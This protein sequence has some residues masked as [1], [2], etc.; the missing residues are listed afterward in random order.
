MIIYSFKQRYVRTVVW[1]YFFEITETLND[2]KNF[3]YGKY[4]SNLPWY[5]PN[6]K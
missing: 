5:S 4:S 6:P 2:S 1:T 3:E